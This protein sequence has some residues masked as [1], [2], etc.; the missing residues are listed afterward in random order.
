MLCS[1]AAQVSHVNQNNTNIITN[2]LDIIN[3]L[4]I[5]LFIYPHTS[6]S[7]YNMWREPGETLSS[8]FN[9]SNQA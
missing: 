6:L 3:Y 2:I 5:I 7:S 1:Y 9:L 4:C 8:V